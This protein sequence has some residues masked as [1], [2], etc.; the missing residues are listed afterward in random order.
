[1]L[2]TYF[3]FG[4]SV[5]YPEKRWSWRK[6][7]TSYALAG[8]V[9]IHWRHCRRTDKL[10]NQMGVSRSL[11]ESSSKI[12]L[13]QL[14][15]GMEWCKSE[16]LP[17]TFFIEYCEQRF[18]PW[19]RILSKHWMASKQ[20]FKATVGS[21]SEHVIDQPPYYR[22]DTYTSVFSCIYKSVCFLDNWYSRISFNKLWARRSLWTR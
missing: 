21:N 8:W 10:Q 12:S 6:K 18:H 3:R 4:A 11:E 2:R 19:N 5:V 15:N 16:K 17:T 14:W 9:Q 13:P 7:K 20:K 1:M 22:I